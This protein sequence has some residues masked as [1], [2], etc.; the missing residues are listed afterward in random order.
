MKAYVE[1]TLSTFWGL[2]K[3]YRAVVQQGCQYFTIG[4]GDKD[5]CGFLVAMFT[6]ALE[7]HDAAVAQSVEQGFCKAGV[8]GWTPVSGSTSHDHLPEGSS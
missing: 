3:G 5:H 2:G 4:E 1:Q 8:A 6:K 7:Y